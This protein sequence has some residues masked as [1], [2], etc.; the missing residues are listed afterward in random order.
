MLNQHQQVIKQTRQIL[1]QTP[2]NDKVL[3][4]ET[5]H[6]ARRIIRLFLEMGGSSPRSQQPANGFCLKKMNPV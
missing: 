3:L 6:S 1:V 5:S 2:G 4:R